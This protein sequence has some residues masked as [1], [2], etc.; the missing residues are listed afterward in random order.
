MKNTYKWDEMKKNLGHMDIKKMITY[1]VIYCTPY[2]VEQLL[3]NA[4]SNSG[5]S[6]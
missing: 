3:K 1:G 4:R 6:I 5:M 2:I